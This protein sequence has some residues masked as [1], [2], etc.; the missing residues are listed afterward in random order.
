[1]S[2]NLPAVADDTPASPTESDALPQLDAYALLS[3]PTL[4]LTDPEVDRIIIDLRARR[5][6]HLASGKPDKPKAEAKAKTPALTKEAKADKKAE[7]T[8]SLLA[9]IEWKL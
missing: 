9:D 6:R 5:A 7:A 4:D 1:M 8:A 3:R 2:D